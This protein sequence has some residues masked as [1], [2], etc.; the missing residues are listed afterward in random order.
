MKLSVAQN[1]LNMNQVK[2][3]AQQT[4]GNNTMQN[5][6]NQAAKSKF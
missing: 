3:E 4:T 6:E 5:M 1:Q 2:Q